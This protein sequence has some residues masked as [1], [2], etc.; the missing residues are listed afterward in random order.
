MPNSKIRGEAKSSFKDIS[1]TE[2]KQNYQLSLK[3]WFI[4]K[5]IFLVRRAYR[6]KGILLQNLKSYI[7]FA[8]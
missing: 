8:K 3:P 7:S 6:R 5:N 4:S 2:S 1:M